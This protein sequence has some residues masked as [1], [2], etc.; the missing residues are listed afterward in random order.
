ML[1]CVAFGLIHSEPYSFAD[2]T[3]HEEEH[4]DFNTLLLLL[5]LFADEVPV[6]GMDLTCSNMHLI[7]YGSIKST[8]SYYGHSRIEMKTN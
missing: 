7:Y 1:P 2:I 5:L 3:I 6:L 4:I 8:T